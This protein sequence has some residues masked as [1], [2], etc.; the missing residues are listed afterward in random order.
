[1]AKDNLFSILIQP[2]VITAVTE[3]INVIMTQ[4]TPYLIALKPEECRSCLRWR[5]NYAVR[6]E[7]HQICR[8][9]SG[10]HPAYMNLMELKNDFT[11]VT[12]T[13]LDVSFLKR[14]RRN[15]NDTILGRQ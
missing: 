14:D 1:M 4:L 13:E 12:V 5:Q 10:V 15:L 2:E 6:V 9:Q 7:S 3:A 8:N 11:A